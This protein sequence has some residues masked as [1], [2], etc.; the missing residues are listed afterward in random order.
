MPSRTGF[1]SNL[2]EAV[3]S[4]VFSR[5]MTTPAISNLGNA[6]SLRPVGSGWECIFS[7]VVQRPANNTKVYA[8][9]QATSYFEIA[10]RTAAWTQQTT[11]QDIAN[12]IRSQGRTPYY[13]EVWENPGGFVGFDQFIF[14]AIYG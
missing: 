5:P 12:G 2:T 4:E 10:G 11:P 6:N 3:R 8:E 14:I 1:V 13:V 9:R 7:Q